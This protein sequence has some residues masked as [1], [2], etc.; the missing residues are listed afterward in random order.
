MRLG[1]GLGLGLRLRLSLG[2]RLSL[3]L[4]LGLEL[5]LP[6]DRC[7]DLRRVLGLTVGWRRGLTLPV[8]R[9]LCVRDPTRQVAGFRRWSCCVGRL[10]PTTHRRVGVAAKA[11]ARLYFTG[12]RSLS[13]VHLPVTR[14]RRWLSASLRGGLTGHSGDRLP[15]RRH[16][17]SG[18][19]RRPFLSAFR[20]GGLLVPGKKLA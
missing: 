17:R 10:L 20:H 7:L 1:L 3:A 12:D 6:L 19:I 2:L 4:A 11:A 5:R 16:R 14:C 18:G 13:R 9:K 15:V 8:S